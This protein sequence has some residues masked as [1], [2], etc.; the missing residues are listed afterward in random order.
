[1][2]SIRKTTDRRAGTGPADPLARAV[3]GEPSLTARSVLASALLGSEPP[4]LPVAQLVAL[5]GLFGVNPNRARVALSRMAAAG[6]VLAI[7]DGRYRLAGAL[8][9]RQERQRASRQP[10]ARAWSG[11]W[12][13]GIVTASGDGQAERVARRRALARAR[14]AAWREGVWLRP[15]DLAVEPIEGVSLVAGRLGMD[16]AAE[17]ELV[18]ALWPLDAWSARARDL[19]D[20]LDLVAPAL[21][22]GDPAALAPGFVVSAAVLRHLQADPLL[23]GGL[24]PPSW[25]G[26]DLRERYEP[27]D[28]AYRGLLRTWHRSSV[29]GTAPER[30]AGSR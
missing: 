1:M 4:E 22:A 27:W 5:A 17:I 29:D 13:L 18:R 9:A 15:D 28:A 24:L 2:T 20:R 10:S 6:E 12:T 21:E 16:R 11:G 19:L 14:L 23:P 25:T 30:A 26:G 8:L 3:A 7:G